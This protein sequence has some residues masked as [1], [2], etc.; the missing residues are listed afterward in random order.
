MYAVPERQAD[1]DAALLRLAAATETIPD[2]VRLA[3][4][5]AYRGMKDAALATLEGR[6]VESRLSPFLKPLH[7]DPRW[8]KFMA[9][10]S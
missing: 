3:E 5:Y 6:V 2:S 9:Q 4:T 1:A 7:A 8:A 10:D